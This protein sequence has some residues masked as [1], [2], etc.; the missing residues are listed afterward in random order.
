MKVALI[1]LEVIAGEVARNREQG[2]ALAKEAAK[3][4]D[5]LMLPEIWTTGYALREVG[6][7]AED[8]NGPTI[9]GLRNIA[10]EQGITIISGSLP[11]KRDGKVYNSAFVINGTGEVIADYQ[12]IHLFNLMGEE[13]FFAAGD[14]RTLF[15]LSNISAG[16]AICYDLRFPELFRAM[17][18]D[19]AK[20]FFIPAEWP[21][22]RGA[23]WRLLNQTRAVENQ[24][25]VCAVNCVGRHRENV[26]Y[27]HSMVVS[28]NGEIIVEA[29]N[30]EGIF[31]GDIDLAAIEEVRQAMSVWGDRRPELYK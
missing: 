19:G 8:I 17:A 9:T 18:V 15:P 25:Y 23:H 29:G 13:R 6:K 24:V 7:W 22:A 21:A 10:K 14:K 20:I 31:Y 1:Q 4:A 30:E 27:G 26:F 11:F 16:L 3:Q 12:K 5:I 28:P 2:L